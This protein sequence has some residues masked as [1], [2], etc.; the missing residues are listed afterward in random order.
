MLFLNSL[1]VFRVGNAAS[2]VDDALLVKIMSLVKNR[3]TW[4]PHLS[5]S[6]EDFRDYL[7]CLFGV[8]S[9]S[10]LRCECL[11]W[12]NDQLPPDMWIEIISFLSND[13]FSLEECFLVFDL[14]CGFLFP[15]PNL[16]L[17]TSVFP[18]VSMIPVIEGHF[19]YD[20]W[21]R[22]RLSRNSWSI[23]EFY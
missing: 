6:L 15:S 19:R 14:R 11:L 1:I 5:F 17:S 3:T 22:H 2:Q 7:L 16:P 13:R 9:W 21:T 8:S 10:T 4:R 23:D 18:L 12:Q 20:E